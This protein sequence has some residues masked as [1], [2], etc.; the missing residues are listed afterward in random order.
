[1]C[2]RQIFNALFLNAQLLVV[3]L[4]QACQLD[5]QVWNKEIKEIRMMWFYLVKRV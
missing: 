4:F 1:M 5:R 2:L 3:L